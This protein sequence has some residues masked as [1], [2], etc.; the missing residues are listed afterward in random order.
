MSK[1][2]L[3]LVAKP[4]ADGGENLG[5]LLG[6]ETGERRRG[7]REAVRNPLPHLFCEPR[8]NGVAELGQVI[9]R[10]RSSRRQLHLDSEFVGNSLAQRRRQSLTGV[11]RKPRPDGGTDRGALLRRELGKG[12]RGLRDPLLKP[13]ALHLVREAL[14]DD[15]A[16][17]APRVGRLRGR[18]PGLRVELR[19]C[20]RNAEHERGGRG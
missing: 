13:A 5:A 18:A 8:V 6:R 12:V 15:D 11:V 2:I 3:D 19:G 16:N 1:P 20:R 17:G 9:R 10:E 14:H 4:C 7:V